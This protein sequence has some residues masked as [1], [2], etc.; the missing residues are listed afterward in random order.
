VVALVRGL[1]ADPDRRG[2]LAPAGSQRYGFA[3]QLVT[4]LDGA[5]YF[6]LGFPRAVKH[7]ALLV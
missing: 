1:G 5:L 7:R 6:K 2:D 3:G 4:R